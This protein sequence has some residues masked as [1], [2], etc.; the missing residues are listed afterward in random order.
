MLKEF[1]WSERYKLGVPEIDAQHMELVKRINNL[2]IA[3]NNEGS[4]REIHEILTFL[5][6]YVIIHFNDEEKL[7]EKHGYGDYE[8]HRGIH[9]D[10]ITQV[11]GLS[12]EMRDHGITPPLMVEVNRLLIQWLS[13][14]IHEEDRQFTEWLIKGRRP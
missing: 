10:Y 14:H 11:E 6:E 4:R 8:K 5:E 12:H 9:N 13:H 3:F 2:V 7:M 1:E